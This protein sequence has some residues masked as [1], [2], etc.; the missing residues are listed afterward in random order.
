MVEV[1]GIMSVSKVIG[2]WLDLRS[3]D[4]LGRFRRVSSTDSGLTR[5]IDVLV[6][7]LLGISVLLALGACKSPSRP[8]DITPTAQP[9][10]AIGDGNVSVDGT[11]VGS[12]QATVPEGTRSGDTIL[13][14]IE[15]ELTTLEPYRMVSI[16]PHGSVAIHLWDTLTL[17]NDNLQVEPHLAE[18]WR[19]VNNF[20][21]EFKLR[22]G[23]AFHNGELLDAEAVRF[24]IE[25]ARSMPGSLETLAE[26]VGLEQVEI[27]DDY[28]LRITT[29][30]PVANLPFHL[31]FLE[32]LPPAYYS[33]APSERLA[34]API[35]SGPYR[36]EQWVPG[37]GLVLEAVSSYWKGAPAL[38]RLIFRTVPSA[39]ERLAALEDGQAVLVTDLPPIPIGQWEY[40]MSTL[41]AVESTQR[42]LIGMRIEAG[43]PLEDKRVRQAL[44]YGVNVGQIVDDWLE[45]Y[46]ERYGSWVNPPSNNQELAS[47]P[48]DPDLARDLLADAGYG[49]GFTTTL[50]IPTG[51]YYQ[52]VAIAEAIAQQLGE[53]GV[54]V[55]VESVDW[56]TFAHQLLS[57]DTSPLFFLGLN[58]RGDGLEDVKNL[59]SAFAFNPTG[60]QNEAFE[61]ALKQ[62]T[63]VF[64][65]NP[66][67]RLLNEA[68]AIAYDEAPWIWLWRSYRFYGV[69]QGLDW[70]PRR[71]GLVCLYKPIGASYES[72]E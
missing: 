17:L 8:G 28:T 58:S 24:S 40:P 10:E 25:R 55:G 54:I 70:M 2:M 3:D 66:R 38:P 64:N 5:V 36:L 20:T 30:Q 1:R 60:W 67:N 18:S 57:G 26:D 27:V 46:G 43:S 41:E 13:I 47:W 7:L 31:A 65:E 34:V 62:A 6:P 12:D 56:V 9:G 45:G 35:G 39:E 51:A 69:S 32:V 49:E 48:Y 15:D 14:L 29:R 33:E 71:D 11:P 4:G 23:I 19:L 42:M 53:I 68:Q 21:W 61:D 52:D 16:H 59:S 37:E 50:R 44:N 63:S 72:G 22:E